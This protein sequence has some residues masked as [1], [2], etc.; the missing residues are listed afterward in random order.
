[1]PGEPKPQVPSRNESYS[2]LE[3][4]VDSNSQ[5]EDT[6][7][8]PWEMVDVSNWRSVSHSIKNEFT[9]SCSDD[10]MEDRKLISY[11]NSDMFNCNFVLPEP[12]NIKKEEITDE[13]WIGSVSK[14]EIVDHEIHL[15]QKV[16]VSHQPFRN[17]VEPSDTELTRTDVKKIIVPNLSSVKEELDEKKVSTNNQ[18]F[19]LHNSVNNSTKK[20]INDVKV[21]KEVLDSFSENTAIAKEEKESVNSFSEN[22]ATVTTAVN[23]DKVEESV[24][25][26][27]VKK[28]NTPTIKSEFYDGKNFWLFLELYKYFNIQSVW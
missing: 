26:S 6:E 28:V 9:D 8:A 3:D 14:S 25:N 15:E 24:L 5:P 7:L 20:M 13:D 4:L 27:E 2:Q 10:E 17:K 18:L 16:E 12:M 1:M 23:T 11:N 22:T 21:K 19:N